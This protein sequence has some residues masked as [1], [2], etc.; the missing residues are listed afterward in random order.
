MD[1]YKRYREKHKVKLVEK[2]RL[3]RINNAEVLASRRRTKLEGRI[4]AGLCS[5]CGK[6]QVL[7][8]KQCEKCRKM[9]A[10]Y[11]HKRVAAGICPCGEK[12]VTGKRCEQCLRKSREVHQQLI[13]EVI[14]AYGGPKCKCCGEINPL[15][16]T[17]DHIDGC[18]KIGRESHGTGAA[19]YRWLKRNNF[20]DGFQVLCANCNHGRAKNGGICPHHQVL[21]KKPTASNKSRA[22][23]LNEAIAAYGGKCI[24]CG[25]GNQLFLGFDH[26]NDDGAEHRK[27]IGNVYIPVWLRQ[28]DYPNNFQILC[29][30]CNMAK[31]RKQFKLSPCQRGRRRGS[32]SPLFI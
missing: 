17:I 20:P 29:D 1:R 14:N 21:D 9:R 12:L 31:F 28:H 15:M 19:F 4:Q 30:N 10:R 3:A 5:L 13:I 16:L 22:K 7:G 32:A 26:I 25:E 8:V 6:V 24:C 2:R 27:Q 23:A 11:Y 18:G